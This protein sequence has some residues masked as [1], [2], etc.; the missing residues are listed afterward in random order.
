MELIPVSLEHQIIQWITFH[1]E[2][3]NKRTMSI[4]Q[5]TVKKTLLLDVELENNEVHI[6]TAA[7]PNF[8]TLHPSQVEAF[9]KS[10]ERLLAKFNREHWDIKTATRYEQTAIE[11]PTEPDPVDKLVTDSEDLEKMV[12]TLGWGIVDKV[13]RN[14]KP[15]IK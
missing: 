15:Q 8:I 10:L 7:N 2:H 13:E 5:R 4:Y 9:E 3:Q 12:D 11:L 1:V 14:R 6:G